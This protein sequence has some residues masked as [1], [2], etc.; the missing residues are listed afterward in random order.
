MTLEVFVCYLG[1]VF[2][3]FLG[4]SFLS[5]AIVMEMTYYLSL[6]VFRIYHAGHD[7]IH[8]K[9]LL[10]TAIAEEKWNK[11]FGDSNQIEENRH[12]ETLGPSISPLASPTDDSRSST[13]EVILDSMPT[14]QVKIAAFYLFNEVPSFEHK[15]ATNKDDQSSFAAYERRTPTKPQLRR[16]S[17]IEES[18]S[19]QLIVERIP[20]HVRSASTNVSLAHELS[21]IENQ[22]LEEEPKP[23]LDDLT[24]FAVFEKRT[25]DQTRP[26]LKLTS[27]D[28][29]KKR[30]NNIEP[31]WPGFK[32]N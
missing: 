27:L 2:G 29:V 10:K 1:G 12:K 8:T 20:S 19:P 16:M 32:L 9:Q 6:Y 22:D 23:T 13:P 3:M 24:S 5:L 4:G 17:T 14:E 25:V 31:L 7:M 15:V 28:S 11:T 18:A 21:H 30:Y 26:K